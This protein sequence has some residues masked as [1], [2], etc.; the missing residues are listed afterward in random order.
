M[1]RSA[2]NNLYDRQSWHLV[3]RFHCISTSQQV[4]CKL[5]PQRFQAAVLLAP[6]LQRQ[7]FNLSESLESAN[8]TGH[9]AFVST[10]P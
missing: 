10:F 3:L 1:E 6:P 8:N 4:M 9:T 7:P 5:S 2:I